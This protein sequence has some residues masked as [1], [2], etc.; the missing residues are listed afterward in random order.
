MFAEGSRYQEELC[1]VGNTGK[2]EALVPGPGRFWNTD[3]GPAPTPKLIHSPRHPTG[4]VETPIPVD[5]KLLA[6]GDHNG[7]TYYQHLGFYNAITQG[8]RVEVTIED[9]L[10]AVVLGLAA[11]QS[12]ATGQA[13]N[14]D[15]NGLSFE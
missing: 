12:I 15:K 3:L 7:S 14:I 8:A 2:L 4:P 6:A 10:K 1:A 5:S 13:I 9:G 11:Q